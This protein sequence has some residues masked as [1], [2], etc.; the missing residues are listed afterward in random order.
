MQVLFY[1]KTKPKIYFKKLTFEI[2]LKI[3]NVKTW[4]QC[5]SDYIKR[6]IKIASPT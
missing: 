1:P 3:P 2:Q 4:S 5:E 6:A